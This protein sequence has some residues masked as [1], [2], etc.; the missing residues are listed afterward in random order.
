MQ[1]QRKFSPQIIAIVTAAIALGAAAGAGASTA[2]YITRSSDLSAKL[3]NATSRVMVLESLLQVASD[4]PAAADLQHPHPAPSAHAAAAD[5]AFAAALPAPDLPS[6]TQLTATSAAPAP[7]VEVASKPAVAER[8]HRAETAPATKRQVDEDPRRRE[9]A[10]KPTQIASSKAE[11]KAAAVS[12][13]P[14]P[15]PETTTTSSVAASP[16]PVPAAV[17]VSQEDVARATARN[18]VV[19]VNADKLGVAKLTAAGV[20]LRSGATIKIGDHFASGERLLSV[21]PVN[22]RIVTSARQV[23]VFFGS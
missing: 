18:P 4:S 23:L 10:A 9:A 14:A 19:G 22:N 1:H 12:P 5:D 8:T 21:D 6:A 13:T 7:T 20:Q 11:T 15:A 3:A 17:P 16:T 2:L